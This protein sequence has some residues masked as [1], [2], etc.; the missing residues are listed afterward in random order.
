MSLDPTDAELVPPRPR[1]VALPFVLALAALSFAA[2]FGANAWTRPAPERPALVETHVVAPPEVPA[3]APAREPE[4][5]AAVAVAPPEP[6]P[7]TRPPA[8]RAP[9]PQVREA[10]APAK[11]TPGPARP[12]PPS[13]SVRPTAPAG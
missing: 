10:P 11:L 4:A 7:P 8:R 5:R 9:K 12:P 1:G 13:A 6:P 3:A 2:G